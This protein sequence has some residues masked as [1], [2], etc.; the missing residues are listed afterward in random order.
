MQGLC[1]QD[2]HAWLS[3]SAHILF[4]SLHASVGTGPDLGPHTPKMLQA[5]GSR[6]ILKVQGSVTWPPQPKGVLKTA[7]FR[8]GS[9]GFLASLP[10]A[11][12][13]ELPA[14]ASAPTLRFVCLALSSPLGAQ[15]PP[16]LSCVADNRPAGT[17]LLR[18]QTR[19]SLVAQW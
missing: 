19:S 10:T 16:P 5:P 14:Y 15:H 18:R 1:P 12:S 6:L 9:L 11:L 8:V 4:P 3:T 13:L 7:V 2:T 17:T